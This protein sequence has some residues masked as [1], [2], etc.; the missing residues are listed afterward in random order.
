VSSK[1]PPPPFKTTK[2]TQFF[3]DWKGGGG[4]DLMNP[5]WMWTQQFINFCSRLADAL[6]SMSHSDGARS[7][8]ARQI[9]VIDCFQSL[10]SSLE[11]IIDNQNDILDEDTLEKIFQEFPYLEMAD[12]QGGYTTQHK[13][14]LLTKFYGLNATKFC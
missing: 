10:L 9:L 14:K 7:D 12:Y 4:K 11:K 8:I 13:G 3:E 5:L 6:E 1:T 2:I